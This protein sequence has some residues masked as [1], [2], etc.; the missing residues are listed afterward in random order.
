M[1]IFPS[2]LSI[3]ASVLALVASLGVVPQVAATGAVEEGKAIAMDRKRGNC[4]SCHVMGDAKLPGNIGPPLVAMKARYPDKARLY[5]QIW[6][7]TER[8]PQSLMPPFG[9]HG[10]LSKGDIDKIVE[11]LLTL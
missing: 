4:M 6:D 7:S 3:I 9:K 10:V 2:G 8:N 1:R 5:A 11:Y